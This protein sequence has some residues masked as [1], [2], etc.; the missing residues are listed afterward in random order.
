MPISHEKRDQLRKR[1]EWVARNV[2]APRARDIDAQAQIPG[3]VKRA[4]LQNGFLS[5]ILPEFY[6]GTGCDI[7]ALCAVVEEIA[8]VCTSSSLLVLSNA[9]GTLPI[10]LAGR[11]SLKERIFD[12]ITGGQIMAFAL[13]EPEAG[14]DAAAL[15]TRAALGRNGYSITGR[16]CFI[17]FGATAG[18]YSAFVSTS[19]EK[20]L[21][22]ISCILLER[23][24]PGVSIGKIEDKMG[25]H[26]S[27]TAEL[28]FDEVTVPRENLV[29][30][31]GQG[32][33]VAMSTLL[34]SRPAVGAQAVGLS[35]GARDH[36]VEYVKRTVRHGR[37]LHELQ[38]VRFKIADLDTQIEAARSLV[39]RTASSINV[40]QKG[41]SLERL[42]AMT[43]LFA[44]DVAMAV[45]G[46]VVQLMED[47]GYTRRTP[48]ERMMRDAKILQIYEGTNQIQR[49]IIGHSIFK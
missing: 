18:A 27:D 5:L 40:R 6:G 42:S 24:R 4:F 17:S 9:V 14:S 38:W 36:V 32:W 8:K 22:G 15:K 44:T 47:E 48:V 2:V 1:A 16:K 25:M 46:E 21:A 23:D 49:L 41:V 43:K 7:P 26:G 34:R 39:Y 20:R 33:Y 29:G 37:P 19:P 28:L 11:R 10:Y 30:E 35:Q 12:R 31:E 3:E 13:T 45:T